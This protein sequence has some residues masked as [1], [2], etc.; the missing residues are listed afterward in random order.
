M[1]L[2][3]RAYMPGPPIPINF[4]NL[5]NLAQLVV[6][7]CGKVSQKLDMNDIVT[8]MKIVTLIEFVTIIIDTA[9]LRIQYPHEILLLWNV[10]LLF[11]PFAKRKKDEKNEQIHSCE[12]YSL[13]YIIWPINVTFEAESNLCLFILFKCAFS[14]SCVYQWSVSIKSKLQHFEQTYYSPSRWIA[15]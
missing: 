15:R 4:W 3:T 10:Y 14:I 7:E 12:Y 8:L 5:L 11:D 6:Y 1:N 2:S 13:F 9:F